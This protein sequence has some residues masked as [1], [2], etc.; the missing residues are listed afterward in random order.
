MNSTARRRH[1]AGPGIDA[2]DAAPALCLDSPIAAG[3]A[4]RQ[5]KTMSKRNPT[6]LL[7]GVVIC[8]SVLL[9]ATLG[10][11][12]LVSRGR[13]TGAQL[14]GTKLPLD[15]VEWG[16]RSVVLALRAGC[17]YC[18]QSADFYRTLARQCADSNVRLIAVLPSD[19]SE[20]RE[21][22]ER[23]GVKVNEV[24]QA[25]LK[26]LG[27]LS[28]PTLLVV[29]NSGTVSDAW[30]GLLSPARE[31]DVLSRLRPAEAGAAGLLRLRV[32]ARLRLKA[33]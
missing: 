1:R 2:T 22:L 21:Y 19:V 31:R 18:A 28:T 7:Y 9:G 11:S 26:S 25:D 17:R 27:V 29:G 14:R 13:D 15:G 12:F 24:R 16:D 33:A 8:V 30:V 32:A 5:A 20:S 6:A 10:A 23:L 4:F 3:D